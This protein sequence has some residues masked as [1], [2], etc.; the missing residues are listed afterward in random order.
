MEA[1]EDLLEEEVIQMATMVNSSIFLNNQILLGMLHMI[2]LMTGSVGYVSLPSFVFRVCR[3][4]VRFFAV[5]LLLFVL[6]PFSQFD[7]Q[8][9]GL[10]PSSAGYGGGEMPMG[11][12]GG[13]GA[14]QNMM[15]PQQQ[16]Q[17]QQQF[18]YDDDLPPS[19]DLPISPSN[20]QFVRNSFPSQQ[21]QLLPQQQQFRGNPASINQT[22]MSMP[23]SSLNKNMMM[24][25]LQSTLSNDLPQQYPPNMMN[26]QVAMRPMMAQQMATAR[27]NPNLMSAAGGVISPRGPSAMTSL[28]GAALP[29]SNYRDNVNSVNPGNPAN[30]RSNHPTSSSSSYRRSDR[31][32]QPY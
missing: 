23:S 24:S 30:F 3:S 15:L 13:P 4:L 17:Q 11:R 25:L 26:R 21:Q 18:Y 28:R 27:M 2:S 9:A 22:T 32:Y 8:S 1:V 5:C 19:N 29:N 10:Y 6:S 16:L 7:L 31:G 20:A 12:R 14:M